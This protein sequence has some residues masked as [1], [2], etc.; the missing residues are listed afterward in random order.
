MSPQQHGFT[1]LELLVALFIAAL[2]FAFGYGAIAQAAQLRQGLS[3]EQRELATLRIAIRI[4]GN[5]LTQLTPRPVRDPTG[6]LRLPALHVEGG[7]GRLFSLTRESTALPGWASS[8]RRIDYR[9]ES[10]TLLRDSWAVLDRTLQAS[11]SR[12][13]LLEGVERIEL[14]Y[15]PL[16]GDWRSDWTPDSL[17]DRPRAI[18]A[19]LVTARYGRIT[20]IFEVL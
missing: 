16:E 7:D 12:R 11:P 3:E 14:R 13:V 18:E 4:L 15:L 5:D 2:T 10:G 19:T 1:L 6:A 8:P 20:R 17:R 9:L